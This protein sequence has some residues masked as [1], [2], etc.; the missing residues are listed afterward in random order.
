[1]FE[2]LILNICRSLK[3]LTVC[4]FDLEAVTSTFQGGVIITVA[5]LA[6]AAN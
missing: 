2:H 5:F 1:M 3:T 6:H 4:R